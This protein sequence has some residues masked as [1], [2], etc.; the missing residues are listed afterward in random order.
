MKIIEKR[1]IDHIEICL[2]KPVEFDKTNGFEKIKLLEAHDVTNPEEIDIS[3]IFLGKKLKAPLIISGMTGGAKGTY[4]INKRLAR[5]AEKFGIAM[6][7]G[8][9]RA[10][11]E[12]PE[13]EYTYKVRNVAKSILLLGNLGAAQIMEYDIDRIKYA[14]E[15]ID[16]DALAI[17]FNP[18]QEAAQPEGDDIIDEEKFLK[19]IG[20][21]TRKVDFPVIVKEVGFGISGEFAKKLEKAGVAAVDIQGAG[22]TNWAK[23]EYFRGGSERAKKYFNAGIKTAESLEQCVKAVKIPIIAS[24]GIRTGEEVVKALA[25]GA[26]LVGMALPFLKAAVKSDKEVH[27]FLEKIISDI[28]FHISKTGA[29]N[30]EELRG[31]YKKI[32]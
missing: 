32:K 3:T 30:L 17:H 7:I 21:I 9:Q 14:V 8:S 29:R 5:G 4:I 11:I 20:E 31:K 2:K 22:G 13:L 28:K 15:M 10:A 1:K 27:S 26:S 18:I 12:N 23:V 24:G 19:R 6:G 25:M 16:A